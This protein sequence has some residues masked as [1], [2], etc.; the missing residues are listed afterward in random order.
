MKI[1]IHCEPNTPP[2]SW[3]R[4]RRTAPRG[5]VSID[6]FVRGPIRWD[7]CRRVLN[8]N[9][10]EGCDRLSTRCTAAQA[11]MLIRCGYFQALEGMEEIHVFLNDCDEDVIL[12]VWALRHAIMSET[13][14]N[15]IFN[16][17]LN[18]EDMLDTTAGAYGYPVKMEALE[19]NNWVFWPYKLARVNGTLSRRDPAEFLQ[20]IDASCDR[21]T[22]AVAGKGGRE[23]LDASFETVGGGPGWSLVHETGLNARV[24][25]FGAG[26]DA[27]V[28]VRR[29]PNGTWSYSVGR[30]SVFIPFDVAAILRALNRA[31]GNAKDPWGGGD[32]IAGSPR[33]S[34]SRLPPE[35][36]AAIVNE[37]V[38]RRRRCPRPIAAAAE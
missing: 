14:V 16:R 9:H 26:I 35:R 12:T 15:P 8:L 24:G 7:P 3:T 6:G 1:T 23:P 18:V 19:E 33:A 2:M 21:I 38:G 20:V 13:I 17:I 10:H 32:T 27:F 5:S 37:V 29:R 34:G 30:R 11:V 25:M 31:E 36:V 22:Q 28:S 4:F